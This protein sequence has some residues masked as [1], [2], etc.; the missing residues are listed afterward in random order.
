M[1]YYAIGDPVMDMA[2]G[3]PM[4]VLDTPGMTVREWSD[5]N[6]YDLLDNYA[7]SKFDP[8]PDEG[9]VEC[10]YLGDVRSEPSKSYTFPVSR[11]TLID[12]HHAD[13]G[14]RISNR[15][16]ERLVTG[17]I[18]AA[19]DHEHT[20]TVADI[21]ASFAEIGVPKDIIDVAEEVAKADRETPPEPD[22]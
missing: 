7:N 8:S 11:V 12:A 5:A 4:I 17:L 19:I 18:G 16:V 21:Q 6:G 22:A 10:V 1:T 9:V 20:P 14:R 3:R 2:Q 15:V 13:S